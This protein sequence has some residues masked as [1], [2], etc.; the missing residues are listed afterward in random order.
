MK[1]YHPQGNIPAGVFVLTNATQ[2]VSVNDLFST[3]KFHIHG[4]EPFKG[5]R[6]SLLGKLEVCKGT[7]IVAPVLVFFL[8][9]SCSIFV[10]DKVRRTL[11]DKTESQAAVQLIEPEESDQYR[12]TYVRDP[13]G[14]L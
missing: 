13:L 2:N 3:F 8:F 5:F 10:A 9:G 12:F 7:S 6:M 11:E 1:K 14:N 4:Y